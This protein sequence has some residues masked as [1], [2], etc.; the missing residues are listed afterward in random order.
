MSLFAFFFFVSQQHTV[1]LFDKGLSAPVGE[2][3]F[4]SHLY[5]TVIFL[6]R[7]ARDKHREN[8]KKARCLTGGECCGHILEEEAACPSLV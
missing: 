2:T 4:L 7:Q 1:A 6:P 3:G 8:S 5:I